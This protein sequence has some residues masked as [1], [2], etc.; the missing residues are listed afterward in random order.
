MSGNGKLVNCGAH[1]LRPVRFVCIHVARATDSGES[2]G[3]HFSDQDGDLP[4][5]AWCEACEDWLRQPGATW[6]DAFTSR[7]QFVPFCSECYDLAKAQLA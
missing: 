6:S 4:P 5:I 7:A 3:F 1:G 2:V